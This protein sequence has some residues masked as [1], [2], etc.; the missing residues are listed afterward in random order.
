[1][2]DLINDNCIN[3]I[4]DIYNKYNNKAIIVTD[5]PFNIGYNYNSYKDRMPEQDYYD[6]LYYVL[7]DF[8]SVVVHYPESLYK[9][10]LKL[11]TP[12]ERIVSWVYNSNT[13]RQHRD[14]AFFGIKPD[15]SKVRQPY[16]NLNDKRIQKRIAEGKTGAKLYDW[17]E[18]N[19]VK[20][21]SKE[22]TEHPCQMP[23]EV[24]KRI[25]G[26]LPEDCVIIDPFMGS[27]STGKAVMYENKERNKGYKYIGIELTEEYLPIA[28]AR[29]EYVCKD[30][31]ESNDDK[32]DDLD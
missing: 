6:M 27:G 4:K 23:L 2:L 26:I 7:K 19:Q 20:N 5:P 25:I 9:V 11:N 16:K 22:K 3:V 29:I 8:K 17:W 10:A 14:I 32:F 13:G 28:Q 24:M 1:M 18:I 21:V 31:C 15:F 30:I 12:P